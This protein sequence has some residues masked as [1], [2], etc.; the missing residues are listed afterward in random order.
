MLSFDF[1][2]PVITFKMMRTA[3]G[4]HHHQLHQV[5]VCHPVPAHQLRQLPA[6]TDL[7]D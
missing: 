2:Y 3:T 7:L 6:L 1:D 4:L 5:P